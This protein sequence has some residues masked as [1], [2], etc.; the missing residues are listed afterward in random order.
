MCPFLA[1]RCRGD[2][3]LGSDGFGSNIAAHM[4]LL[5]RSWTT[6]KTATRVFYLESGVFF[7]LTYSPYLQYTHCSQWVDT[8]W[9]LA[10]EAVSSFSA[11]VFEYSQ[12][13]SVFDCERTTVSA[14]LALTRLAS[15][16]PAS[17]QGKLGHGLDDT[18]VCLSLSQTWTQKRSLVCI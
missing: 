10:V 3:P 4:L 5:S 8:C 16:K 2:T 11:C 15:V 1:A 9:N 6:W 12:C 17:A 14:R 13:A 7:L 18:F